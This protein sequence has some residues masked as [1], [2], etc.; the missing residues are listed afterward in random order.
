MV[1]ATIREN[2]KTGAG[3]SEEI[4]EGITEGI[5]KSQAVVYN[6]IKTHPGSSVPV[7]ADSTG[8]PA[9]SVERH[10][11]VLM[12]KG[13]IVHKGSKRTGGYYPL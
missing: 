8:I 4:T 10:V 5:N 13:L 1:C 11:G 12:A 6:Y 9:K 7:N 3:I 2:R